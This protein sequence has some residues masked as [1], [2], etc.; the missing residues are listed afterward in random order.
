MA[1]NIKRM[2]RAPKRH[3]PI[4]L[5][6]D[7]SCSINDIR[8]ILNRATQSLLSNLKNNVE[9]RQQVKL[10][11]IHY[12][13]TIEVVSDFTPAMDLED[14]DLDIA[15]GNGTTDTGL[16]LLSALERLDE[17]QSI[18]QGKQEVCSKPLVFLLTDGYPDAG[19]G[20]P[21]E[22]VA[23]VRN[24]YEEAATAI[25]EREANENLYFCAVGIQRQNG[26]GA[27]MDMLKRLSDNPD[28]IFMLDDE[29]VQNE[30][31]ERFCQLIYDTAKAMSNNTPLQDALY[32]M[33]G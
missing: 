3:I 17:M 8:L 22:Y 29:S 27:N 10:L 2:G 7:C 9:L 6:I 24:N 28:R 31:I 19:I 13:D 14:A 16:A 12:N 23:A 4:A 32:H 5:V 1:L 26:V 21:E 18:C 15:Q 30:G 33:L 25:R 20:A 11:T